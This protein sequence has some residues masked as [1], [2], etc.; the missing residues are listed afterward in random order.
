MPATFEMCDLKIGQDT[1]SIMPVETPTKINHQA[2][3]P[4]LVEGIVDE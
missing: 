2:Q 1:E 3:L 4:L